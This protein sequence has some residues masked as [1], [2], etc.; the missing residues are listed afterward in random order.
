MALAHIDVV[1]HRRSPVEVLIDWMVRIMENHPHTK[2]LD[3]LNRMTDEDLAARGVTRQDV[4]RYIF[5]DRY[6]V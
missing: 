5:R 1:D 6:Y 2:Q 3:Q 4:I